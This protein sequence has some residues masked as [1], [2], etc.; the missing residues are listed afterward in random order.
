MLVRLDNRAEGW[1]PHRA[2]WLWGKDIW[3]LDWA[4]TREPRRVKGIA[5]RLGRGPTAPKCAEMC[6]TAKAREAMIRN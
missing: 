4:D 3:N 1:A 5:P 2:G 6:T